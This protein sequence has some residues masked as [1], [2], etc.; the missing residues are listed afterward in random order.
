M[1]S[2]LVAVASAQGGIFSRR[3]ALQA[4]YT[5]REIKALTRPEGVWAVV[6]HGVYCQRIELEELGVRDRWIM[7]DRAAAFATRRPAFWSHDSA[8]RLLGIDTLDPPNHASHLTIKGPTGSRTTGDLVR[9]RDLLPL[10]VERVDDHVATSYAR[11]AVDIARWHGYRHGLVAVD[12]VR[13]LGVPLTDLESELSRMARHPHI[14]RACAAVRDSDAGA[15]SVLET[16]GREL[17]A[18]LGLGEV[19]TQFSL[20]LADGRVVWCDIRVGRHIFE[21]HGFIKLVP[22]DR[23]GVATEPA[24]RVLWKQQAR[25]TAIGAEGF[26]VS[27]IVWGDCFGSGREQALIR[28][29]KE[30]AVTEARFGRE[31][32]A[33]LRRFADSHPRRPAPRLWTPDYAPAA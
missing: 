2:A 12:A 22:V 19:E 1:R 21:C 29:R 16:L 32:P 11:T 15:E 24:E 10:C 13:R 9:H 25:E 4:G 7:K 5:E 6:R 26:G 23:G 31:L 30:Y 28:L 3:Q 20:R 17:V 8:A 14:S 27:R 18:S 33:H